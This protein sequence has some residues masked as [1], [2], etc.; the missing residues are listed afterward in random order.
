M[1]GEE[2]KREREY[3]G[4]KAR[5]SIS[6]FWLRRALNCMQ[7]LFVCS[8]MHTFVDALCSIK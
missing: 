4:R 8:N 1:G 3:R 5:P 6:H 7:K 2:G